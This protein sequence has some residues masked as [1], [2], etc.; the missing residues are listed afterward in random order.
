MVAVACCA[1]L[2]VTLPHETWGDST[3]KE[4]NGSPANLPSKDMFKSIPADYF[5]ENEGQLSNQDVRFY[6]TSGDM[7]IGFAESAVLVWLEEHGPA[8]AMQTAKTPLARPLHREEVPS[9]GLLI[10]ITFEGSNHVK[11]E[12]S[13]RLPHS[14]NYFI[15]NN[16]A[17]WRTGVPDYG[18]VAYENLYDGVDVVYRTGDEGLKYDLIVREGIDL[19][20]IVFSYE[21][22]ESMEVDADGDL[23]VHTALGDL[24]DTIPYSYQ[25][26]GEEVA[27]RYSLRTADSFGFDCVGWDAFRPLVIDPLIYSTFIGGAGGDSGFSIAV[28]SS[29]NAYVSGNARSMDFPTTPGVF[30]VVGDGGG[31]AFVTK[32]NVSGSGLVYSTF[33]G[34]GSDECSYSIT[35]DSS[36]NAYL[37][38]QTWSTAFPTTPGAFDTTLGG[39][40]DAFVAKLNATGGGLVY[41]TFLG[42]GD[43]EAG[44]TIVLDPSGNAYVTGDTQST[45]FPTTPGAFDITLDGGSD[46]FVAKLNATGSGLVYSTFLGG[47]LVEMEP[48][49]ALDSSG[50]VY[51]AGYTLSA[52]FPTIPGS[53]DTIFNGNSDVFVAKLNATGSGLIFSTF[54]GGSS[55]DRAHSVIFD[56]SGSAYVTGETSSDDFPATPG[57]F[58]ISYNGGGDAFVSKLD[59]TGSVLVYSTFLGGGVLDRSYSVALDS[60]GNAYAA[61]FTGSTDFP[62][63]PG[64]FDTSP[65]NG[66]DAFVSRLNAAGSGLVYSTFLGGVGLDWGQSLVVDSS[67]NVYMTGLTTS[68]NFPTTPGAFDT[69]YNGMG[70]AFVTMLPAGNLPEARDLLVDNFAKV[71]PGI[72]HITT[73]NPVFQWIYYHPESD[74]QTDYEVRVGTAPGS[75]DKWSPGPSG[76]PGLT[77]TYAG[78]P[79]VDGTNYYFAV[80]VKN[81]TQWSP[82]NETM[83]HTNSVPSPQTTPISPPEASSAPPGPMT[84]SWMSG[85]DAE[86]DVVTFEWEVATDVGFSV[87]IA[88]GTTAGTESAPFAANSATTYYWRVRARDSWEPAMWSAYGNTAPGYWTFSTPPPVNTP[89]TVAITSPSGGENWAGGSSH[90]INWTMHDEEDINANLTI[91]INY[92]T[93]GVT[94]QIVAALK[95][96]VS[97]AWTLPN[98]E[99]NDIVVNITVIDSG[100]LKGWSQSGPFTIKAPSPPDFFSQYWWL[101]VVIL[102]VVAVLLL[103]ALMKRRKPR[104]EEEEVSPSQGQ[105]QPP[106]E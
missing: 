4:G 81:D 44:F 5:I 59:M 40:N 22:I 15:G 63:T 11:P 76:T 61:G 49:I 83:F 51:V 104:E 71:T 87:T 95:G 6:T 37:T 62:T 9:K 24:V 10:R 31:D 43:R 80:R 73:A 106:R 68:T 58:D 57:A 74:P 66:D 92:T 14:R 25:G 98:I 89:P 3:A 75:S 17:E 105:G 27:C 96:Q 36:G 94:S 55:I 47:A 67:G 13:E 84:I 78:L 20:R 12:G 52:D 26:T 45:D 101:V 65:N 19:G 97:F 7:R 91:Y 38:G 77:D 35:V 70:D 33:L 103:L 99:A 93:G 48:C 28:D 82:W 39:S 46:I 1:M 102:A 100:G 29:G 86:G 32:L 21:G 69:S 42:G 16:S 23:V 30:D 2:L 56:S 53:F 90:T 88:S 50:N 34:G 79:L 72:L 41:S 18:Q 8:S 85:G 54:L 60:S 64:A